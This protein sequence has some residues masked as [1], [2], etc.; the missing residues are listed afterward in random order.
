[1]RTKHENRFWGRLILLYL[2]RHEHGVYFTST[3]AEQIRLAA[4][5]R[6]STLAQ[7]SPLLSVQVHTIY[8]VMF[9]KCGVKKMT[10]QVHVVVGYVSRDRTSF[11]KIWIGIIWPVRMWRLWAQKFLSCFGDSCTLQISDV[12]LRRLCCSHACS[13]GGEEEAGLKRGFTSQSWQQCSL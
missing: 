11:S 10:A 13:H 2:R 5:Q 9:L 8:S 3:V 6:V 1:M 4:Q 7:S 12:K